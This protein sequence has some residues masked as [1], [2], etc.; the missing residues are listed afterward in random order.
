MEEEAYDKLSSEE[1]SAIHAATEHLRET[2]KRE[3]HH[4][5]RDAIERLS[6][7]TMRLAEFIMNSAI[8]KALKDKRVREV[9]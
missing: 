9:Q 7:A 2:M 1:K 3:D 4:A 8:S 6:E 5:I